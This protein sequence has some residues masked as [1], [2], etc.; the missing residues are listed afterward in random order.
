MAH[1]GDGWIMTSRGPGFGRLH[2]LNDQ[3]LLHFVEDGG[4]H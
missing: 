1:S 3:R 2:V 4:L